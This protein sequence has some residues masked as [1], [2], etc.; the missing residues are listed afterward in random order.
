MRSIHLVILQKHIICITV[1]QHKIYVKCNQTLA[2]N[3]P[4]LLLAIYHVNFFGYKVIRL[5][6][7]KHNNPLGK[8]LYSY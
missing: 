6:D 4:Q 3:I 5:F 1:Y 8:I 7:V 2:C